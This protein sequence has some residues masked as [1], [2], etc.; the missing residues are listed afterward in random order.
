MSHSDSEV[1]LITRHDGPLKA[2][3]GL[4]VTFVQGEES[5][6]LLRVR[7]RHGVPC[8]II[9]L[10]G[11]KKTKKEQECVMFAGEH[12]QNEHKICVFHGGNITQ[13]SHAVVNFLP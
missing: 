2:H 1:L 6:A 9:I 5:V 10:K 13:A 3:A 7:H 11:P 8:G 4:T 12:G